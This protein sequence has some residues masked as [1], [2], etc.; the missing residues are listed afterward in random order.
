MVFIAV[1]AAGGHLFSRIAERQ[2]RFV[3]FSA[4]AVDI[5][6]PMPVNGQLFAFDGAGENGSIRRKRCFGI[7]SHTNKDG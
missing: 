2:L 7:C 5:V 3:A 6:A 1:A 4:E